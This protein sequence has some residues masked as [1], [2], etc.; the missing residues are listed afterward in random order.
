MVFRKKKFDFGWA[1]VHLYKGD[2]SR[3]QRCPIHDTLIGSGYIREQSQKS[4]LILVVFV[5]LVA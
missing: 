2:L 4:R 3:P 5:V 1:R